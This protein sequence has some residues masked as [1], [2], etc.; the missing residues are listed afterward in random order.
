MDCNV[1]G[2]SM[3]ITMNTVNECLAA[4]CDASQYD[5]HV[6]NLNEN[7]Q[8]Q[9]MMTSMGADCT[10]KTDDSSSNVFFVSKLASLVSLV[11]LFNAL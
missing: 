9:K 4:V 6:A 11:L 7:P 5:E 1:D 3:T 2:T 8:I 10:F